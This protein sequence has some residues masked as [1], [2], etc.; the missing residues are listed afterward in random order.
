MK[1]F[2][3]AVEKTVHVTVRA[4][5]EGRAIH[6]A[7]LMDERMLEDGLESTNVIVVGETEPDENDTVWC[8]TK[9]NWADPLFLE[10]EDFDNDEEI[11]TPTYVDDEDAEDGEPS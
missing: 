2:T 5:S 6:L 8:E 9:P 10:P 4:S 7:T 1:Y 3:I 11:F